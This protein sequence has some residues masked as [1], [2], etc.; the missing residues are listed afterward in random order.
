MKC[1]LFILIMIFGMQACSHDKNEICSYI[2]SDNNNYY[3]TLPNLLPDD[4]L[5][6]IYLDEKT[7]FYKLN[8]EDRQKSI[9]NPSGNYYLYYGD[10]I[11]QLDGFDYFLFNN[12]MY[13][14]QC[15]GFN[16]SKIEN[17]SESY[18][19]TKSSYKA[20]KKRHQNK[21]ISFKNKICKERIRY[22]Q[23]ITNEIVQYKIDFNG[24]KKDDYVIIYKVYLKGSFFVKKY[25]LKI[26]NG[27]IF[28]GFFG[29][30]F[31]VPFHDYS[32]IKSNYASNNSGEAY[33]YLLL[34]DKGSY[35]K[36]EMIINTSFSY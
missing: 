35:K 36:R 16:Y 26:T 10:K 33:D 12:G 32:A 7:S 4:N 22:S 25:E 29:G 11:K 31:Y 17:P 9:I 1:S 14:V 27:E 8:L 5:E 15:V 13:Y 2:T 20:F 30:L 21:D 34:F 23:E 6:K 19:M 18:L 3:Y 24:D 28:S